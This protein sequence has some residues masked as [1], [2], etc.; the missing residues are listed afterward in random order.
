MKTSRLLYI[1][2]ALLVV[3]FMTGCSFLQSTEPDSAPKLLATGDRLAAQAQ[4]AKGNLVQAKH[5]KNAIKQY[6]KA[7]AVNLTN[8][9]E[10]APV[11]AR[12]LLHKGQIYAGIPVGSTPENGF[13]REF[14]TTYSGGFRALFGMKSRLQNDHMARD[15]FRMVLYKFDSGRSYEDLVKAY[16]EEE[17]RQI[18]V[19]VK[20]AEQYAQLAGDRMDEENRSNLLYRI[21][22]TLVALT[23]RISWFSYWFAIVLATLFVKIITMP[24]T[25]MQLKNMK[26]M[27]R[28]GPIIKQL[29]EK[30][31]DDPR[32]FNK[33]MWEVYTEHGVNPFASCL[34]LLIQMP[35]VI[36][37]YYA[38]RVYENQF[39]QGSFLWIGWEPLEHI[40]YIPLMGRPVWFTA[41][42][43]AQPDL[44]LLV[45]YTISMI[46][47]QRLSTVDPSQAEQQ[48][49]MGWAMAVMFFFFIGY[50]PS[51]FML[52]WLLSNLLQ[53][54]QQYRVLHSGSVE[55]VPEKPVIEAEPERRPSQSRRSGRRRR[56]R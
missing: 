30:Y 45:L 38:I 29:Q 1:V 36:V 15:S 37:A 53:T 20:Q 24:L 16:G 48:K 32:E 39:A 5:F 25:K 23:F 14:T 7:A 9:P 43:L 3:V 10:L 41:Q 4:S 22:D 35:I 31:K 19:V 18:N 27:Q 34:P 44:L 55:A 47:A 54:W 51:A 46:V 2:A 50:L 56:R 42:S 28:V 17:A 12:A 33:K 8:N 52:F 6:D 11:V 49:F 21:M 13:K 26:E 40:F